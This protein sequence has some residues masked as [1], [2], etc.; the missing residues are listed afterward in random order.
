MKFACLVLA[1]GLIGAGCSKRQPEVDKPAGLPPS[2]AP[3]ATP[4]SPPPPPPPVVDDQLVPAA[5]DP[6]ASIGG[7]ITLPAA[8]KRDVAPTDI[9]FIIA[10]KSGAAPGPGSML[11]VQKHPVGQFP[12]PFTLSARDAMIPGTPF[13]GAINITVRLDKDGD[14]LTRKKGDLYG[15]VNG[16]PVGSQGVTIPL[17]SVQAQDQTLAGG[18]VG[19]GAPGPAGKPPGHP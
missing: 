7:T 9:V 11:A 4:P 1:V 6:K 5:P 17:D 14:G 2:G 18:A 8:R 19:A 3:A 16:V 13:E 12:M 10:R 15:Q